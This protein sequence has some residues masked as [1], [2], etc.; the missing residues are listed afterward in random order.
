MKF[1]FH[2]DQPAVHST[3]LYNIN[4]NFLL[5]FR[6]RERIPTLPHTSQLL[7]KEIRYSSLAYR[8]GRMTEVSV[9]VQTRPKQ[10][11][12]VA[13]SSRVV[14]GNAAYEWRDGGE[15]LSR[16]DTFSF[17]SRFLHKRS[18]LRRYSTNRTR[19]PLHIT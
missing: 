15:S 5:F 2:Y 12:G 3:S 7:I 9:S 14:S 10:E 1:P 11:R 16:S 19:Q 8:E 4:T 6:R 18:Y 13:F 17:A